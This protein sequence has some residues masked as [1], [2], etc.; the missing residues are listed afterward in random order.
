MR[1]PFPILALTAICVLFWLAPPF[2]GAAAAAGAKKK[3]R[4]TAQVSAAVRAAALKKVDQDLTASAALALRQPGALAPVFE[5]LMRLNT[6]QSHD[7]VHILHFGDSH[8]AADEWTG[9]LRDLF[10]QRFGDGGSGF[11]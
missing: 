1:A 10:Q 3:R 5:Q 11:S 4:V 2:Q 8:T 9:G 7:P 6:G